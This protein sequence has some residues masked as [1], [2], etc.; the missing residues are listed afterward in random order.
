M[1][2]PLVRLRGDL[3][4]ARAAPPDRGE[5]AWVAPD[6]GELLAE[7]AR[8]V[9]EQDP[10]RS[11]RESQQ[12]RLRPG[13]LVPLEEVKR[14]AA[15]GGVG[16]EEAGRAQAREEGAGG[17]R[18]ERVEAKR[19]RRPPPQRPAGSKHGLDRADRGTGED[20]HE[21]RPPAHVIPD[22]LDDARKARRRPCQVGDLVE[23]EE[24]RLLPREGGEEPERGLPVGEAA[25]GEV[26]RVLPQIAAQR[27]REPPK[28]DG[29]S[30]LGRA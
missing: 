4:G 9:L 23:D 26:E 2:D 8:G 10:S 7:D 21:L 30:L 27:L 15:A 1:L 25:A 12:V 3:G 18:V 24:E 19:E 13:G 22:H 5:D 17:D 6:V 14:V 29:L 28:L 11:A 16:L 20:K